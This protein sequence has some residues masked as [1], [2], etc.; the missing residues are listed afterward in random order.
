MG[1]ELTERPLRILVTEAHELAGLGAV[2]S[3]GRAGHQ[4]IASFPEARARPPVTY[5]RYCSSFLL[6]PDPWSRQLD[7]RDWWIA[8]DRSGEFDVLLPT[9]EAAIA[10]ADATRGATSRLTLM[11]SRAS[12]EF[13]LSKHQATR[14]AMRA[15]IPT[16]RTLFFGETGRGPASLRELRELRFP[17]I[18]KTDN[19]L[20][21]DGT[22]AKG[23]AV[24]AETA[25]D[26]EALMPSLL[27]LPTRLI[28]QE[29]VPGRGVGAFYLRRAGRIRRRFAHRRLHEIPA[30]GGWSSLRESSVDPA[31]LRHGEALLRAVDFEGVAM[32]E[33]RQDA[34]GVPRFLEINGRL[35]GS[36]ALALHAGVDFPKDWLNC[37]ISGGSDAEQAS[38]APGI[39]CRSHPGELRRLRTSLEGRTPGAR[40]RA[41]L[42]F[43]VEAL[44]PRVR[45]DHWWWGDPGPGWALLRQ[46][47][48]DTRREQ[49]PRRRAG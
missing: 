22:Y 32:V 2:R 9:T 35:W 17:V 19:H 25:D 26:V 16:P 27:R 38:W 14:A 42:A 6:Q 36:L 15:G 1:S 31:P 33:F 46:P 39:V 43:T 3:L 20:R 13:S 28:V 12:L 40:A 48:H 7:F 29:W 5:S 45:H 34:D 4:V 11:A 8:R 49:P 10:A 24:R 23:R 18:L 37:E 47:T 30:T 41:W 44:D 21:E